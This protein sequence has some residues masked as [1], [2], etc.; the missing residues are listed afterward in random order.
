MTLRGTMSRLPVGFAMLFL[1]G[2]LLPLLPTEAQNPPASPA[3]AGRGIGDQPGQADA[4]KEMGKLKEKIQQLEDQLG[5]LR[6]QT[7]SIETHL[8]YAPGFE[9]QN[10]DYAQAR[11]RSYLVERFGSWRSRSQV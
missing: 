5:E 1:A 4:A 9:V 11:S 2:L 10:E 3:A 7:R 6:A 8:L